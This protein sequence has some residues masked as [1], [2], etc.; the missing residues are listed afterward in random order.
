M[1]LNHN[2]APLFSQQGEAKLA[3]TV[4]PCLMEAEE[5]GD[6]LQAL[7]GAVAVLLASERIMARRMTLLEEQLDNIQRQNEELLFRKFTAR[8]YSE[9]LLS[10]K[11]GYEAEIAQFQRFQR[12]LLKLTCYLPDDERREA[13]RL[14]TTPA[15]KSSRRGGVI[16]SERE[17]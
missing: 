1:H 5:R 17:L 4:P 16:T 14:L 13:E 11:C 3:D 8:Y 9:T 12:V 7:A 2:P 6:P 10:V 15:P